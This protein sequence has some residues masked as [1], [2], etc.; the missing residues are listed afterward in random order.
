MGLTEKIK[1][2]CTII[3]P[4]GKY[5]YNSLPMGVCIA[6]DVFQQRL[7]EILATVDHVYVFID[8]ILVIGKGSWDDHIKQID[9]VLKILYDFGMQV[10]PLKS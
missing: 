2:I 9:K 3:L 6:M 7:E 10:N 8:D 5:R 4:W 1:Q